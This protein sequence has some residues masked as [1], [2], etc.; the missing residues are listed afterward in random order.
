MAV[1][2]GKLGTV[3]W[4]A[5]SRTLDAVSSDR[6]VEI[7][8]RRRGQ[9]SARRVSGRQRTTWTLRAV[10]SALRADLCVRVFVLTLSLGVQP[11][12]PF[13]LPIS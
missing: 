11:N 1:N 4:A 9:Q 5:R 3:L 12:T 6:S 10:P 13:S 7:L 2:A 8:V